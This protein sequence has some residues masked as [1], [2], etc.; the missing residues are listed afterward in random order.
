[1]VP[2]GPGGLHRLQEWGCQDPQTASICVH[3]VRFIEKSDS[4]S[5]LVFL[6][7]AR[8]VGERGIRTRKTPLQDGERTDLDAQGS[9]DGCGECGA[10]AGPF[11]EQGKHEK[12]GPETEQTE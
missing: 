5:R 11:E 2:V 9:D 3:L 10:D 6:T 1:M 12:E 7:G 4:F 8:E